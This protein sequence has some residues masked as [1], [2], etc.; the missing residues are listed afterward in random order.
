M[1]HLTILEREIERFKCSKI[2]DIVESNSNMKIRGVDSRE[3]SFIELKTFYC[4]LARK[5]TKASLN[6]IGQC[7]CDY[8]KHD[9]V[10]HLLA[11]FDFKYSHNQYKLSDIFDSSEVEARLFLCNDSANASIQRII[12]EE[13]NTKISAISHIVDISREYEDKIRELQ[14]RI[15]CYELII[16]KL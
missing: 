3:R 11:D 16:K 9:H 8:Y 2:I 14:D 15:N 5:L 1:A 6:V 4:V 13:I 10:L 12:D 7:L